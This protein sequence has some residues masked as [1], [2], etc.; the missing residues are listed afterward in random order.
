MYHLPPV[1]EITIENFEKIAL[2]RLKCKSTKIIIQVLK[3]IENLKASSNSTNFPN[4]LE[5]Q[6][7]KTFGDPNTS[8]KDFTS[9]HILRLSFSKR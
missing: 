2:D 8:S 1:D 7:K 6:D 4:E 9:H 5:E 3:N